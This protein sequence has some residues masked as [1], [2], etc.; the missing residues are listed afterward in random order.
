MRNVF[1]QYQVKSI[2]QTETDASGRCEVTYKLVDSTHVTKLKAKCENVLPVPFFN[3]TDK[4]RICVISC[5][6]KIQL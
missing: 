4:V 2:K 3:Q 6:S 5:I 1:L